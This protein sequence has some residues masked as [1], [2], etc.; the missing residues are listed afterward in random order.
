MPF[1]HKISRKERLLR[2]VLLPATPYFMAKDAAK[3]EKV[4]SCMIK[5]LRP[6]EDVSEFSYCSGIK[7]ADVKKV[8]RSMNCT[9]NDLLVTALTTSLTRYCQEVPV[10]EDYKDL[11]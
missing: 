6:T 1:V 3:L 11:Y 4:N 7:V 9:V 2:N 5:Q 8:C 10:P